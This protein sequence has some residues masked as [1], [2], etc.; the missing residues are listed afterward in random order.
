MNDSAWRLPL[1]TL[2]VMACCTAPGL[3]LTITSVSPGSYQVADLAGGTPYFIDNSYTVNAIPLALAGGKLVRTAAADASGV[4]VSFQVD[5]RAEVYVCTD[6]RA[7]VPA[8]LSS[9]VATDMTVGV[10]DTDAGAYKVYAK[11][12]QAGTVS[13]PASD[14]GRMYFVVV[15]ESEAILPRCGWVLLSYDMPYLREVIRQAPLYHVNHIQ[16]SHDIMMYVYQPVENTTLRANL[17]ELIDLAHAY[18]ITDVTVWTHE[19]GTHNLPANCRWTDGRVDGDNSDTWVWTQSNYDQLFSTA[20]PELD[21]VVVTFSENEG[22]D[23]WDSACFK[24]TGTTPQTRGAEAVQKVIETVQASCH[25]NVKTCYAR[26][27]AGAN[28][29]DVSNGIVLT[30]D[31]TTWMMSKNV[32]GAGG[33]DWWD[34]DSHLDCIGSVADDGYN[35]MIEF[36]LCGEYLGRGHYTFVTTSYLKD[37][38]WNWAYTH[39]VRGGMVARI[40]REGSLTYFT[41]NRIGLYALDQIMA[42]GVPGNVPV[43]A[44]VN[45]AWA[46]Q[47]FPP[48]AAQD[49]ADHYDAP[50]TPWNDDTRYLT[51][52]AFYGGVCPVSPTDAQGIALAAIQRLDKHR[53]QLEIQNTLNTRDGVNDYLT[54]RSGIELPLLLLGG[55]LPQAYGFS[56]FQPANADRFN[57]DCSI[58]IQLAPT[59]LNPALATCEYSID[60]GANWTPWTVTCSGT[61]GTTA[62][63]TITALAVPFNQASETQ[64]FIRFHAVNT[65]GVVYDSGMLKVRT[66]VTITWSDFKPVVTGLLAPNCSIDMTTNGPQLNTATAQYQYSKDGGA[67][68]VAAVVNWGTNKYECNN[69]PTQAGWTKVEGNS[70][71]NPASIVNAPPPDPN[72]YL[73]INDT[74]TA[75][76]DKIKYA[77]SWTVS[78]SVGATVVARMRCA[79]GGHLYGTNIGVGDTSNYESLYLLASGSIALEVSSKAAAVTTQDWHLYRVTIRNNDINVY[80][81]ENPVPIIPG[82]GNFIH[83]CP[84]AN[85]QQLRIGSGA[86]AGTQDIYYDYVYWTTAGAFAPQEWWPAAWTGDE[87]DGTITATAV[88]FNQLTNTLNKIRFSIDDLT[89]RTFKSPVYNLRITNASLWAD[90]DHDNDADQSDFGAF[91]VC[92]AG[93]NNPLPSGCNWADADLDN[94]VDEVD[95]GAFLNCTAGPGNPPSCP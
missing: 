21:G 71:Y 48:D 7:T 51:W 46:Q 73:R 28:Q 68:W 50:G 33:T 37:H 44:A 38:Y 81:D 30:G 65:S 43:P 64:N 57:P 12:F 90:F 10:T 85:I 67:T 74:S 60:G 34:M 75:S 66:N 93:S 18:G 25:T 5:R 77:K 9:W 22:C 47:Y 17:N 15:K 29:W 36:D 55:T 27:W 89:G 11:R 80:L 45:L 95:L 92:L 16:L 39:G 61:S 8:W 94:D 58:N 14:T 35:E 63:Q 31:K 84:A 88:P 69:L 1:S 86:S 72:K 40:D 42:G 78:P 59:G 41:A 87:Y 20:C 26:T 4:S 6:P 62:K 82:N 3:A 53:A 13:L 91:Q 19:F 24:F 79:S 83:G 76:G 49:I 70:T 32:G 56:N 52:E 54:L 23:V 2:V